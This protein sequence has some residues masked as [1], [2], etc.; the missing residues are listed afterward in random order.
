MD[1]EHRSSDEF[2]DSGVW[3]DGDTSIREVLRGM[4]EEQE[5]TKLPVVFASSKCLPQKQP[6]AIQKSA[7]IAIKIK[8]RILFINATD[9]IA[10]EAKGNCVMLFHGSGSHKLRESISTI[11]E[12]LS[13]HGFVRIHRS[14][15]V[16]AAMVEEINPSSAG[17]YVLRVRGGREFTVSR[18]YK[19]NLQL[20]AQ[21]WIGMEGFASD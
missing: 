13:L 18:T 2:G 21:S 3:N 16:N 12:K 5:L 6:P 15:L 17:D 8:R 9:L 7:R 20:L 14:V 10:V 11:E 4:P 19:K 1:L